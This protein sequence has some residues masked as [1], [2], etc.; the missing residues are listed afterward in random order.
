M[1]NYGAVGLTNNL[2]Q[3]TVTADS[4]AEAVARAKALADAF[5]ADHV[6][7]IKDAAD[8]EAKALLDQ[9]DRMQGE[10][11][12]VNKAIGDGSSQG[13]PEGF[14]EPG[15]ALR[16]PGRTHLRGS[17]I[18]VSARRRRASARPSHRLHAGRGRP[19]RGAAL[20]AQGRCHQRR[21]RTRPRARPRARGGRGRHGG[22]GPPRAAPGHRGE[23]RRLGHHGAAPPVGQAVAAPTGPGGTR[24]AHHVTG[25]HRA[26][27]RGPGL[28]AGTGP[29]AAR[30]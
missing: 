19:A 25:P 30:A 5:V 13:G 8:S 27:L 12:Q 26:R 11:A 9:R 6:R 17:P 1:K 21:D 10:L 3:I 20:P 24:T 15:V 2:L 23:P 22:G 4:D 7:R 16:Q 29:R 14:G 28:A 18:S